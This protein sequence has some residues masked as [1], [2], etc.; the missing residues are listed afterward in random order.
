M[1]EHLARR[2]E[3]K[4]TITIDGDEVI[5]FSG[6][7]EILMDLYVPVYHSLRKNLGARRDLFLA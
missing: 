2:N 7:G 3:P 1:A 4:R 5:P 6:M